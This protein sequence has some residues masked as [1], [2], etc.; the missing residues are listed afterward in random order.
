MDSYRL[1]LTGDGFGTEPPLAFVAKRTAR[2]DRSGGSPAVFKRK[3]RGLLLVSSE[4]VVASAA[5]RGLGRISNFRFEEA[6]SGTSHFEGQ[7]TSKRQYLI[8]HL[9][10]SWS[11][12]L[13][14]EHW[15]ERNG[16]RLRLDPTS[17]R[18]GD[19][20]KQLRMGHIYRGTWE[21]GSIEAQLV[22]TI[23]S[24]GAGERTYQRSL[25]GEL[26]VDKDL[27]E[28]VAVIALRLAL[29]FPP[30]QTGTWTEQVFEEA[31]R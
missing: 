23:V 22:T 2:L 3:F 9:G 15:L 18:V 25:D 13:E 16:R 11:L 31:A 29:W 21:Q 14:M 19:E 26:S 12:K 5:R 6:T 8:R 27:P 10:G 30:L 7:G 20:A 4:R 28:A 24:K 1:T 17:R